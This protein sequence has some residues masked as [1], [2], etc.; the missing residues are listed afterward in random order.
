MEGTTSFH[1]NTFLTALFPRDDGSF[2]K[3]ETTVPT[4]VTVFKIC[5]GTTLTGMDLYI[6][7][8]SQ[9]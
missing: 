2:R 1:N 3:P 6:G 5:S 7:P 8:F 9:V 4:T